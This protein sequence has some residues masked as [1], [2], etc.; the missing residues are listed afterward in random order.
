MSLSYVDFVAKN[1]EVCVKYFVNQEPHWYNG[2]V[3]RVLNRYIDDNLD[4]CVRCIVKYGKEKYAE[5][6]SEKD[7]NT[8]AE[9][10]WCFG[11][12]FTHL[13]DNV[14]SVL[15]EADETEADETEADETEAGEAEASEVSEDT[16]D[17]SERQTDTEEESDDYSFD[18]E[19]LTQGCLL[20]TS[21][22]ADE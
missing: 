9:N 5:T 11:D 1:V 12:K 14:K 8:D 10:A 21:D 22:A 3:V 6:F 13:V 4:E 16:N 2:R 20:Y 17:K 7:F 18:D 15:N 19:P